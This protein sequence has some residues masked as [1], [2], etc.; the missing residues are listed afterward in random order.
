V[1]VIN[2]NNPAASP[3]LIRKIN[4]ALTT[5][6]AQKVGGYAD[7]QRLTL[8]TSVSPRNLSTTAVF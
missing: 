2:Q 3:N 4:I 5:R 6:T 1:P 8:A 7:Y